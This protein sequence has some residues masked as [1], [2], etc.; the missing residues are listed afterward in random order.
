MRSREGHEEV[1]KK[2]NEARNERANRNG[3]KGI[4]AITEDGSTR[5]FVCISAEVINQ[6]AV[7]VGFPR[8]R[9]IPGESPMADLTHSLTHS[10]GFESRRGSIVETDGSGAA[11]DAAGF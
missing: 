11:A 2:R 5:S 9:N 8:K 10:R 6:Q 3:R 1:T 4:A 7:T